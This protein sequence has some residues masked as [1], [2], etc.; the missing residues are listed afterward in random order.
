MLDRAL[1][2]SDALFRLVPP[3]PPDT[4]AQ[5]HYVAF[6]RSAAAALRRNGVGHVVGVTSAG[7]RRG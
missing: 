2:G 1:R 7:R 3:V 5:E 4:S 6:A